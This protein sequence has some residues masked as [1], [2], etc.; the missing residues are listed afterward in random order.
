MV[1]NSAERGALINIQQ[2]ATGSY[3]AVISFELRRMVTA[4][5]HD[6]QCKTNHIISHLKF[7]SY[8]TESNDYQTGRPTDLS[9]L[10]K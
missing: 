8:L 6:I 10:A 5:K 3:L 1:N 7:G 9:C 4:H 2:T